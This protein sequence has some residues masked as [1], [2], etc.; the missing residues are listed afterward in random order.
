MLR[1][2][3][4]FVTFAIVADFN[5]CC[6]ILLMLLLLLFMLLY[7][8]ICGAMVSVLASNAVDRGFEPLS[9]QHKDNKICTF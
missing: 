3:L 6:L 7:S 5:C 4:L 1:L 2:L 9:G 8:R